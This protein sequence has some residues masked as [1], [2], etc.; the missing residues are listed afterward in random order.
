MNR[1]PETRFGDTLEL[2]F[3]PEGTYV[4]GPMYIGDRL[5][6]DVLAECDPVEPTVKKKEGQFKSSKIFSA[7]MRA[8]DRLQRVRKIGMPPEIAAPYGH[9]CNN[10]KGIYGADMYAPNAVQVLRTENAALRRRVKAYAAVALLGWAA[11]VI[12]GVVL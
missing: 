9:R 2:L 8:A 1:T 10:L 7:C 4:R 11:V 12:M 3:S 5:L 6:S